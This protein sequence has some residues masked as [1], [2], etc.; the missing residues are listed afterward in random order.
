MNFRNII[1]AGVLTLI[2][3][4]CAEEAPDA[5][6][7]V[8]I[9]D[10]ANCHAGS[11]VCFQL[12]G[13]ADNIVFYSGE[14]GHEYNLRD[15]QF[16]DNDLMVEFVSFTDQ[17]NKVIPNFQILVSND[18]NGVYDA[19]N[20]SAATWSDVTD[21]FTL[22]SVKG[23]NTESGKVN[24][25]QFAGA[26]NDDLIY[27][28]FRYFDL[29]GEGVKNRW[30][31]RSFNVEK[32]SPEGAA[33]KLADIKTAGWQNVA[34]SGSLNWTLPGSQLLVAGN[35]TSNDKDVWAISKGFN[36]HISEPSTG[37]VLKNIATNLDRFEYVYEKPGNYQAVF[38]TSSVWYNSENSSL[39]VVDVT[40]K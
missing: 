13:N 4:S 36:S 19:D 35:N 39:T 2:L 14:P 8:S 9:A 32:V 24:L 30:V 22:P 37:I 21:M 18:F 27:F 17:N 20:V 5:K 3:G 7:N 1:Y 25:K 10:P 29:N 23:E 6:L 38:A 34:L 12:N 26:N 16:A 40:V 28:A 11:P 31:V 15:R 33:T